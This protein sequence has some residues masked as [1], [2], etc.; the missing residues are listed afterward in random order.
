MPSI[1]SSKKRLEMS[2][3]CVYLWAHCK[4]RDIFV[5]KTEIPDKIRSTFIDFKNFKV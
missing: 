1:N 4:F 5:E 2:S 3:L